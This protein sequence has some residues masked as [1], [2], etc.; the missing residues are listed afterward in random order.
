MIKMKIAIFSI[1]YLFLFQQVFDQSVWL[2][3]MLLDNK[4]TK[5][6]LLGASGGLG[7]VAVNNKSNM[8][9]N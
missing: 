4:I 8:L 6:I 1:L 3:A 9:L 2:V 5:K 7:S